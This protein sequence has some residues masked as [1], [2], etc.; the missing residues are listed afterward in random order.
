M[1]DRV[2]QGRQA[3]QVRRLVEALVAMEEEVWSMVAY[4][5]LPRTW[6]NL[7]QYSRGTSGRI[8]ALQ[9]VLPG[10]GRALHGFVLLC[11]HICAPA[12]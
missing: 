10:D 5:C 4:R 1:L 11:G 6:Q 9:R 12:G 2:R 7:A 3:R 8:V